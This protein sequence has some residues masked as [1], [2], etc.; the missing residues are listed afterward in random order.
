MFTLSSNEMCLTVVINFSLC[1]LVSHCPMSV[2]LALKLRTSV[3]FVVC[4]VTVRNTVRLE[5]SPWIRVVLAGTELVIVQ[6]GAHHLM[7]AL[8][9]RY[10]EYWKD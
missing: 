6:E 10:V 5:A 8:L 3:E 9:V 7:K 4:N 1:P 2:S